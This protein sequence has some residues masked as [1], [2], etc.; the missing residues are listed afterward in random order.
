MALKIVGHQAPVETPIRKTI[1]VE[2]VEVEEYEPCK[3]RPTGRRVYIDR[4]APLQSLN[5]WEAGCKAGSMTVRKSMF[6][7][8]VKIVEESLRAKEEDDE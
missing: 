2:L 4:D 6:D 5:G 1:K 8:I 3:W 7:Q